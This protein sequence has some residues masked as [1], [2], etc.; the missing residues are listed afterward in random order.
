MKHVFFEYSEMQHELGKL[1]NTE[2]I[3]RLFFL[4]DLFS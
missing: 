2:S 4:M 3:F 1:A